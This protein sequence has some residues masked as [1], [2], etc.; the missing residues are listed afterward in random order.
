M[1][2]TVT[3]VPGERYQ[4]HAAARGALIDAAV[5]R[6]P[7]VSIAA[8]ARALALWSGSQ[9]TPGS[10][11]QLALVFDLGL[12][13]PVGEHKRALDRLIANAPPEP[14]SD[15]ETVLQALSAARFTIFRIE[16]L[17]PRGGLQATD[18]ASGE[19]FWLQDAAMESA[20]RNWPGMILAG[21]LMQPDEFRMTCN[22]VVPVDHRVLRAV[23]EDAAPLRGQ[24]TLVKSVDPKD[25]AQLELTA[26]PAMPARLA[27]RLRNAHAAARTYRAALDCGL[28]GPIP[29][30]TPPPQRPG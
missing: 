3:L 16:G 21:H 25:P 7:L 11:A 22:A 20:V 23:L 24:V 13:A 17:D 10:E 14:G 4:R 28:M 26:D 6:I 12:L 15:A 27:E 18:L 8:Q 29:G 2:G 5:P 9:V 1:S 19:A 30:R